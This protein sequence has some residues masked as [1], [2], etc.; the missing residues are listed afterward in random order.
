MTLPLHI[1][2]QP[3]L[4]PLAQHTSMWQTCGTTLRPHSHGLTWA[5]TK[6]SKTHYDQKGSRKYQVGDE[7]IYFRFFKPVGISKEF[8]TDLVKTLGNCGKALNSSLLDQGL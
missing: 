4:G 3:E 2:Y 1:S 6:G 7:V 8:T 5:T